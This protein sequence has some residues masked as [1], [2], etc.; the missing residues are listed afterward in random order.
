MRNGIFQGDGPLIARNIAPILAWA[1]AVSPFQNQVPV[2]ICRVYI[3]R[4]NP[5]DDQAGP[6]ATLV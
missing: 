2:S 1:Y 3:E 4:A 6:E 5:A